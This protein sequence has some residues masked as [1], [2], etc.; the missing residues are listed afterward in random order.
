[1]FKRRHLAQFLLTKNKIWIIVQKSFLE[2]PSMSN[3][4]NWEYD[5]IY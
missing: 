2:I 4:E 3:A 1:M 5:H